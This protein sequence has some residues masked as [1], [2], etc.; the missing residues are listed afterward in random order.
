MIGGGAQSPLWRRIICNVF[1]RPMLLPREGDSSFGTALLG[2]VG[3]GVF[4]DFETAVRRCVDITEEMQPSLCEH[5]LYRQIFE[6]YRET[7]TALKQVYHSIQR[8]NLP[9]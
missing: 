7:E 5:D 3:I 2:G 1:G 6:G 4:A 9:N 8:L